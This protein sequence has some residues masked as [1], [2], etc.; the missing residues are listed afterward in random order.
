[1]RRR[2]TNAELLSSWRVDGEL[3]GHSVQQTVGLV[4]ALID[5][6]DGQQPG[7]VPADCEPK[8]RTRL[9]RWLGR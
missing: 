8:W 1:V 4:G 9:N 3:N 2:L 7:F 6:G 5:I